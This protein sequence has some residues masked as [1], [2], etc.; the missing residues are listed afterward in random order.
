MLPL[1]NPKSVTKILFI[2][3]SI[4]LLLSLSACENHN[5]SI[6]IAVASNFEKT[7]KLIVEKY[8]QTHSEVQI[9]IISAS[10][11]ILANQIINNAP[12]DLFLS[13]DNEKTKQ[14]VKQLNLTN[15]PQVYAIGQ[16]ALWLPNASGNQCLDKLA[17][18]NTLAIANPKTA[19]YGKAAKEILQKNNIKVKKLIQ[20]AN[21][22]QAYIYTLDKLTEAGFVPYSTLTNNTVGCIQIFEQLD[23]TQEM[24][25]LNNKA[26]DIHQ[27]I[28][29]DEIKSLIK[30]AG[31]SL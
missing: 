21:A 19:P 8:K 20:T 28:L 4:A 25:L 15:K 7:L 13:A 2:T 1:Y 6:N 22:T 9:N 5:P 17:L 23:L 11:G 24:L 14:L 30:R 16:L 31:Y 29:S 10:S 3:L 27:F 26:Q 12:F 18:T